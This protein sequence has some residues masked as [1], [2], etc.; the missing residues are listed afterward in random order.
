[1]D[2]L[3]A[4]ELVLRANVVFSAT[5]L[6]VDRLDFHGRWERI[7][8]DVAKARQVSATELFFDL[9]TAHLQVDSVDDRL[10]RM[11]QLRQMARPS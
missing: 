9:W 6:G 4:L 8:T 2:F 1:L 10:A 3:S 11:G 5:P 7:D